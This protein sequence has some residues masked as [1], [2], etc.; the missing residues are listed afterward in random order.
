MSL[1]NRL[2]ETSSTHDWYELVVEEL[3]SAP[4]FFGHGTEN[5]EQ[6]A[7]WIVQHFSEANWLSSSAK[8]ASR[9]YEVVQGRLRHRV[10][11]AYLL[12]ESWFAGLK[13]FVD[14]RVLIPRSPLA[15]VIERGLAPWHAGTGRMLD[16]GTGSGCLALACDHY[17]R[18]EQIDAVDISNDALAVAS[19]NTRLFD[20]GARVRV[21]RS[22][23]FSE[24][25]DR[26]Y[27]VIVTNPPYVPEAR[28]EDLP[29]EYGHEPGLALRAGTRGLD[30][31]QRIFEGLSRHLAEDGLLLLEVGEAAEAVQSAY[32]EIPF[33]WLE[34][35]RGGEGVLAL[36]GSQVRQYFG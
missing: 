12:Q 26:R 13:F 1:L 29:P 21:L 4:L 3:A 23:V 31:V 9:V 24:L 16:L 7:F 22:D 10:P 27:D 5:V 28:L 19:V 30:I 33:I 15:E 25:G 8:R 34:F 6:E 11:L 32:P 20:A 2:L 18:F 35:E 17:C 36:E 14:T